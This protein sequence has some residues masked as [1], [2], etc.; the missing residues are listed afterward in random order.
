MQSPQ[1]QSEV[2]VILN[3]VQ[4]L[5]QKQQRIALYKLIYKTH[6]ADMAWV[7]RHLDSVERRDIFKYIRRMKGAG[8][9]IVNLDESIIAEILTPL[10]NKNISQILSGMDSDDIVEVLDTFEYDRSIAIQDLL[11]SEEKED[12][13]ELIQYPEESAGRIMNTTFL[14]FN[15]NSTVF[16]AI[17]EFQSIGDE[18]ETTSYIYVVDE[19]S[20]LKGVLSLRHLLLNAHSAILKDVMHKKIV[21]V[22][23][24]TDQ[25]KVAQL[26]SQ[27][28]YLAVPVID[29]SKKMIGIITVDDVVD[30]I[31][32]EAS[33][34][35]LK[36]AGVGDDQAILLKPIFSNVKMRF[37]WLFASWLGGIMA[38]WIIGKFDNLLNETI[39]LVSFIPVIMGMG[40]NIGMQ[41][42]TVIVRGLA[43]GHVNLNESLKVVF[44]ELSIGTIL[45]FIY[46]ILLGTL[47]FYNFINLEISYSLGIIVGLSIC[48]A[49]I[50]AVFFGSTVP[51]IL[52]KLKIDPAIAT[53]PFVTTSIDILG[54][55]IY[56]FIAQLLL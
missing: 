49:M 20:H 37:P 8:E 14:T 11:S 5:Y 6:P 24:E 56:F 7:F 29:K 12:V 25:E 54:I 9:F 19:K 21:T 47:A 46:G 2:E 15:E 33:E 35:I 40:G 32:E 51:I 31:Q 38:L 26:V 3:G 27:Y 48:M 22:S 18:I 1:I 55:S 30:I 28:N 23:P 42:S 17:N 43:T 13:R 44:K 53:G 41:T 52:D 16:D 4:H 36:M 34:D 39:A 45:G 50:I 10:S